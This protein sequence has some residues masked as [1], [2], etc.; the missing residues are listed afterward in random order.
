MA[1]LFGVV[2]C[3]PDHEAGISTFADEVKKSIDPRGLQAWAVAVMKES[4][5]SEWE[6]PKQVVPVGIRQLSHPGS[7]F[8]WAARERF[9]SQVPVCVRLVWGGEL[10]RHGVLVGPPA[11]KPPQ[12]G[13]H[14]LEWE[15]GVYFWQDSR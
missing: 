4:N 11:F 14:Y 8:Q 6:V 10:G 13:A 5:S 2:A 1:L 9:A 7:Q 3:R 12:D 15:P